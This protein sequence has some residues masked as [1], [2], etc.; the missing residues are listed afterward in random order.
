MALRGW[1]G[2]KE[3]ISIGIW[4]VGGSKLVLTPTG[5]RELSKG[6][7]KDYLNSF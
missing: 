3:H 7:P 5:S 1:T 6:F 4:K 2:A